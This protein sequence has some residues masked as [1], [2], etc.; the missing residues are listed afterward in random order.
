MEQEALD[1]MTDAM[2]LTLNERKRQ[3]EIFDDQLNMPLP[4]LYMIVSEERGELAEAIL[5]TVLDGRHPER[6]GL[7]HILKEAVH[8]A[9]TSLKVVEAVLY[10]MKKK[11]G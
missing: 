10:Q 1:I 4:I 7:D 9:A 2:M 5:E 11:E 8:S 3:Q 6:G